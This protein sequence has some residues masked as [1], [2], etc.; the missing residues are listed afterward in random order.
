MREVAVRRIFDKVGQA[1]PFQYE[2]ADCS[3]FV[4]GQAIIAAVADVDVVVRDTCGGVEGEGD[5]ISQA[6]CLFEEDWDVVLVGGQIR[7]WTT[8]QIVSG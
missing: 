3:E 7:E 6:L 4:R 1:G 5:V 8:Q 2:S